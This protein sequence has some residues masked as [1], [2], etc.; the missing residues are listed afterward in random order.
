MLELQVQR[1]FAQF[2]TKGALA[3]QIRQRKSAGVAQHNEVARTDLCTYVS[4]RNIQFKLS[5]LY[6]TRMT[7]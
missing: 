1:G 6:V 7:E 4:S 3:N 5:I 2:R